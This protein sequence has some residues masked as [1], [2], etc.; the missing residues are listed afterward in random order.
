MLKAFHLSMLGIVILSLSSVST[1]PQHGGVI[2]QVEM[3]CIKRPRPYKI[4]DKEQCDKYYICDNGVAIPQLCEDGTV[5]YFSI[6]NCVLLNG[7]DCD[8]RPLLQESIKTK[9][10]PKKTGLFP[11]EDPAQCNKYYQCLDG[12]PTLIK[13]PDMLL[14][15]RLRGVCDYADL[16]DTSNCLLEPSPVVCPGNATPDVGNRLIAHPTDCN[17]FFFCES[18]IP[19]PLACEEHLAFD[20]ATLTCIERSK[21]HRCIHD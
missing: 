4:A 2:K 10:C 16:A 12:R 6:G 21:V 8:G 19:R 14:F 9:H 5:F 20:L 11:H 17:K 13:C 1:K 3:E 15:D 7:A 18:A